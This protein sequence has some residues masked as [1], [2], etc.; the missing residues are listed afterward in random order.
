MN[1]LM[2]RLLPIVFVIAVV[3]SLVGLIFLLDGGSMGTTSS[4]SDGPGLGQTYTGKQGI[5]V[6]SGVVVPF[7][8]SGAGPG[9]GY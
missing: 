2:D 5:D 7:D 3:G 9:M 6:G 4:E 8:G 1:A